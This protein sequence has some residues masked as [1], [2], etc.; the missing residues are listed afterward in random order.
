ML[1]VAVLMLVATGCEAR[2]QPPGAHATPT[3][4]L[5]DAG[6]PATSGEIL[7]RK[8]S[9]PIALPSRW[10]M[11][12]GDLGVTESGCFTIGDAVLWA[13]QHSRILADGTAIHLTGLGT[14]KVGDHIDAAGSFYRTEAASE[15]APVPRT[16]AA[17]Q[18]FMSVASVYS[19][20]TMH[21]LDP[22]LNENDPPFC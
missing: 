16:C 12:D 4:A 11:L 15:L 6:T 20:R 21:A 13:D 18:P 1:G 8:T 2:E 14:F 7:W 10:V 22:C 9:F 3:V 19:P 5:P 17:G